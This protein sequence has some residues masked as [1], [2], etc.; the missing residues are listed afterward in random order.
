MTVFKYKRQLD[1]YN[2]LQG[3]KQIGELYDDYTSNVNNTN[4]IIYNKMF[5]KQTSKIKT[6]CGLKHSTKNKYERLWIQHI[7]KI[8]KN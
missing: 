4:Y 3:F 8:K 5:N 1:E 2:K 6:K 7:N